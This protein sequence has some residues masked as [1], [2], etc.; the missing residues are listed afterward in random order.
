MQDIIVVGARCAGAPTAMLLARKGFRV[1]L[2][3]RSTFPSD[4]PHGH[5]I[6][7]QGPRRLQ[8]WGLLDR[9]VAAGC[10]PSTTFTLDTG[11]CRIVGRD[12]VRD[13][14]AAG[15]GPRRTTLDQILIDGAGA[16]GVQLREGFAVQEYISEDGRIVG[17]RG[18]DRIGGAP[19]T[20]RAILTRRSRWTRLATGASSPGTPV[21]GHLDPHLLAIF[22]LVRC[23]CH[24]GGGLRKAEPRD[25]RVSHQ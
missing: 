15:Y 8:A 25:F 23:A 16:A 22:I 12:L 9:I 10:P 11:E 17:I 13:G 6:H 24:R 4:I 3:D 18:R 20:E 14:V 5:F 19:V 2:V 21:R 1:L 7:K